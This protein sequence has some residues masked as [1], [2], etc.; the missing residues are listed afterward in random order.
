MLMKHFLENLLALW[1]LDVSQI[2]LLL[3]VEE[4]DAVGISEEEHS[5]SGVEDLFAVR[6]LN[7]LR[8]LVLQV[9]DDQLQRT[10]RQKYYK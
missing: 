1:N 7:L 9:L 3:N 6:K 10:R 8:Q 4:G 2:S 5:G